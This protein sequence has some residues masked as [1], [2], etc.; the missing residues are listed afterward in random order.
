MKIK[1]RKFIACAC[2]V[3][4]ISG[5][6][7]NN[8]VKA[9]SDSD[10]ICGDTT[11]DG[12][13]NLYD[14]IEIAKYMLGMRSF[15]DEEAAIADYNED[16]TVDLYDAIAIAQYM[17]AGES[18]LDFSELAGE[19]IY[20]DK[21]SGVVTSDYVTCEIG[22]GWWHAKVAG[23]YGVV[24]RQGDKF[25]PLEDKDTVSMDATSYATFEEA[26]KFKELDVD[27][28]VSAMGYGV[29]TK[30]DLL[31]AYSA[32]GTTI[33]VLCVDESVESTR[34]EIP[35]ASF[36]D[37]TGGVI[38]S[39][40]VSV[41]YAFDLTN[42]DGT[43]FAG[44]TIRMYDED[45]STF[46]YDDM[47]ITD[48][49]GS[50]AKAEYVF[51]QNGN[52]HLILY[53]GDGKTTSEADL[54]IDSIIGIGEIE[55]DPED[56]VPPEVEVTYDKD[57]TGYQNGKAFPIKITTNEPCYIDL[58]G[59]TSMLCTEFEAFVRANGVYLIKASDEW[60]NTTD[61]E[62]TIT[63]F[64]DG[65]LPGENISDDEAELDNDNPIANG[66]RDSFWT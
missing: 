46:Y 13:V 31:I 65:S 61:V 55:D 42:P 5:F 39:D 16:G 32:D 3:A 25:Y 36:P 6:I 26:L 53:S 22:D 7:P 12:V 44:F 59:V 51:K 4:L 40:D 15:T 48:D 45:G 63:A 28:I 34:V 9:V 33:D 62:I 58:N 57:M 49:N 38:A 29:N 52:F 56:V 24:V 43:G 19:V 11:G 60:G 17:M 64:E 35:P 50:S 8:V 66:G 30:T 18:S 54:T 2:A 20:L 10:I 23:Y 41:T 37:F 21:D 47:V 27:D 14:V 1:N